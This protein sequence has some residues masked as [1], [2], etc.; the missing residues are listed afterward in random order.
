MS[1]IVN[2]LLT[3][4]KL[5]SNEEKVAFNKVN[6]SELLSSV[7]ERLA[8]YAKT[9]NVQIKLVSKPNI[10]A[11]GDRLK[12]QQAVSNVLKNAIDYSQKGKKVTI[13][14][15]KKDSMVRISVTDEGIGI[16]PADIPHIFD[17]FYRTEKSRTREV[18]GN[19]LGLPI[20]KSI[21]E[22]HRGSIKVLS[23]EKKGTTVQINIPISQIS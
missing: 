13:T 14:V 23:A 9:K 21:I 12:L 20:A 1:E 11:L 17:R 8:V 2:D 6:I 19:G 22:K 5:D 3:L 15:S 4:S 16:P 7:V 10:F 18:G